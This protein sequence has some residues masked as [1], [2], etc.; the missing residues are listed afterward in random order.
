MA[1]AIGVAASISGLVTVTFKICNVLSAMSDAPSLAREVHAEVT[2]CNIVFKTFDSFLQ[3]AI[4]RSD[5]MF[6]N[7]EDFV[8][9]LTG[10]VSTFAELEQTLDELRSG[11]A[12]EGEQE[13]SLLDRLK[14][15]AKEDHILK[16]LMALQNHKSSL[17]LFLT[18][19]NCRQRYEAP[20]SSQD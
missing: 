11:K 4:G 18:V 20:P 1:E 16:L 14:W 15:V 19:Y 13:I 2:A 10:C 12:K 7:V 3:E 5:K 17:N 8:I 9:L 6:L